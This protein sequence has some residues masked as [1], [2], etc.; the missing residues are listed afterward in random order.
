MKTIQL[1]P[2]S[3]EKKSRDVKILH[4]TLKKE[5]YDMIERGIKTEEYREVKPY[6][7]KRFLK[8]E[9]PTFS[10]RNGHVSCNDKGYTHVL[11]HY[12]YTSRGMVFELKDIRIGKG[13][14]EWGAPDANVYIIS[15]GQRILRED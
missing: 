9:K 4:L 8:W 2:P 14:K 5:W 10:H 11:L 7:T 15:L 13:R 6:W 1:T 12:G 3:G